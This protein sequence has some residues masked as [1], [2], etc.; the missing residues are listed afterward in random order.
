MLKEKER[1]IPVGVGLPL[2]LIKWVDRQSKTKGISRGAMIRALIEKEKKR[3]GA[4][5]KGSRA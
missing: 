2:S 1:V 4:R 3:N 5:R